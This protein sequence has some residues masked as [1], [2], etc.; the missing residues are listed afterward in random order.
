MTPKV[1]LSHKQEDAGAALF[2]ADRL[3]RGGLEVYLDTIDSQL[4][5]SGPD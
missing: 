1:F 4:G 2:V 5:R 3:R